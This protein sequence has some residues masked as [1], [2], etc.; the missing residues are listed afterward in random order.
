MQGIHRVSE[1][2]CTEATSLEVAI[3]A[4]DRLVAASGTEIW[5]GAEP[6]FT[7]R[8][9]TEPEWQTAALGPDK[10]DRARQFVRQCAATVPGCVVLRTVGRQYPGEASPRWN[11]GLYSRRDGQLIWQGPP[12]PLVQPA[13]VTEQ[14]LVDLH[15]ALTAELRGVGLHVFPD[16]SF[17]SWGVRLLFAED[18]ALLNTALCREAE[19]ARPPL[20]TH[21]I[22]DEGQHDSLA[23]QGVSLVAIGVCESTFKDDYSACPGRTA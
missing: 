5:L 21:P 2:D 4:H 12:D 1:K 18:E 22:P 8:H 6:T 3:R 17:G 9:S 11:F 7:D 14:Q 16:L 20:H 19:L 23:L 10:E 15:A 13:P